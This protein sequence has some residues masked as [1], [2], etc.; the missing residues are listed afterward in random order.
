MFVPLTLIGAVLAA[1]MLAS[2]ATPVSPTA[3]ALSYDMPAE[4]KPALW[5][6]ADD[7]T[8]IYL[9]GTI[10]VLPKDLVWRTPVFDAALAK[11]ETLVLEVNDLDDEQASAS[12]FL[13]LAISP[14]LLPIADRI[15]ADRRATLRVMMDK[16]S[17]NP[18]GMDRFES[19]AVALSLA[20]SGLS[21]LNLNPEYGVERQLTRDFTALR[22]PILGLE[23]SEEQLSF[24]DKLPEAAQRTLLVSMIDE[25]AD[26]KKTFDDMIAAWSAGNEQKIAITFDD[27]LSLS[28]ELVERLL[29]Q[30]NRNWTGWLQRRLDQPGTVMVAVGAGHLAGPDSVQAMLA[31]QGVQVV[32]VQ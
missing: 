18:A 11:A 26:V 7:D 1:V 22:K 24:F 30:R 27:E 32:R 5:K 23:T 16:A 20:S 2:A 21:N 9:F 12:L 14:N 17:I 13:K 15:P 19:W 31:A 6:L 25:Q 4:V 28:P 8:T 10:H 29:R 3:P